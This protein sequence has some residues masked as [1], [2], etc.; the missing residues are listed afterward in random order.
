MLTLNHPSRIICFVR[1][2][3]HHSFACL[4]LLLLVMPETV[5]TSAAETT[6]V[7][8]ETQLGEPKLTESSGLVASAVGPDRFWSHNDS[9]GRPQLFAFDARS[10]RKTGECRLQGASAIDWEDMAG[11]REGNIARLLVAD[12]G[13]NDSRRKSIS[14][15][16]F[17]EPDPD[18][19]VNVEAFRRIVV[20]YPDGP[21]DCEAVAVDT[22][23]GEIVMIEKAWTPLAG[24]YVIP[25]PPRDPET[26]ARPG[27]QANQIQIEAK[28]VG[29][30]NIPLITGMDIEAASG[31]FWVVQYF[32]AFHYRCD[33]RDEPVAT[34]L[35]RVAEGFDV[36]RWRQIEAIAVEDPERIWVTTEGSP[37]RM[38][39]LRLDRSDPAEPSGDESDAS[40]RDRAK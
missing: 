7:P 8:G 34:Q 9:G 28:R 4:T 32:Q 20:R 17:D 18:Q 30:V 15:Y 12:C 1:L 31:D 29:T 6:P 26:E 19:I 3:D 11:Y 10:G 37:A 36:P 40:A 33:R 35:M 23:R 21:R 16:L 14:L 22:E 38:G 27:E 24:I 39:R 5:G 13:D 2:L 25:L